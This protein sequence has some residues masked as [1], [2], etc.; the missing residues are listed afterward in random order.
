MKNIQEYS[1]WFIH[2]LGMY[3]KVLRDYKE[4]RNDRITLESLCP[5]SLDRVKVGFEKGGFNE[6]LERLICRKK[7]M[8]FL[9][10]E[11]EKDVYVK[12]C[13]VD[14]QSKHKDNI[15][16]VDDLVVLKANRSYLIT[17]ME[18][19]IIVEEFV[20]KGYTN[21]SDLDSTIERKRNA[22]D[23]VDKIINDSNNLLGPFKNIIENEKKLRNIYQRLKDSRYVIGTKIGNDWLSQRK[24]GG[25]TQYCSILRG[26]FSI[27][28]TLMAFTDAERQQLSRVRVESNLQSRQELLQKEREHLHNCNE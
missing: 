23:V 15:N 28:K 22:G 27:H 25:T 4:H 26:K 20:K 16:V 24:V 2:H 3:P 8:E 7:V 19:A 13:L 5:D 21:F 17:E 18:V 10:N 1:Q 9:K 14:Q 6:L 11:K 12:F